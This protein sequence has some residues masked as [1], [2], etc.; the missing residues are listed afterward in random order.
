MA[1]ENSI[2]KFRTQCND[3]IVIEH[4]GDAFCCD[5]FVEDR[6]RL[7]NIL[8]TP[9][10]KLAAGKI[11]REFSRLK[12]GISNKC[13]VCRHL[14]I[15][16]GG[17]LK[18]RIVTEGDYKATSYFCAGY[19]KFFDYAVPRFVQIAAKLSQKAPGPV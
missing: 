18:D 8:E 10:E 1:G 6:W 14:D 16:R 13:L 15:C 5:F 9:I 4:N 19:K 17:C 11:K 7:G 2:C 12:T 3:Y